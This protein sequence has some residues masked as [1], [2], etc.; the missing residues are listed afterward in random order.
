MA[1]SVHNMRVLNMEVR[2]AMTT[3]I[4]VNL[5]YVNTLSLQSLLEP[6][7]SCLCLVDLLL[8]EIYVLLSCVRR[9]F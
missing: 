2:D 6:N 3:T 5:R 9:Y 8:Q 7:E 1:R 4:W